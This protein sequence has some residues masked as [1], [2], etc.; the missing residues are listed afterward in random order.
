VSVFKKLT[1]DQRSYVEGFSTKFDECRSRNMENVGG[2]STTLS[3]K[4]TV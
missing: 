3:S 1:T 4:E 2:N